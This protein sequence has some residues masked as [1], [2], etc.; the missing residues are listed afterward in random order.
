MVVATKNGAT[1]FMGKSHTCHPQEQEKN[2][3]G[4][5]KKILTGIWK[6]I[7]ETKKDLTK[8]GVDIVRS[9]TSKIGVGDKTLFWV[10]TWYGDKPL[11]EKFP[12]IYQLAKEKRAKVQ[13]NYTRPNG[14][15]LWDWAWH[16]TPSTVNERQQMEELLGMLNQVRL[17]ERSDYWIWNG[18]ENQDF[19]VKAVRSTL[20]RN[21]NLNETADDFFW[22]NWATQKCS[23]FVRRAIKGKIPTATKLRERGVPVLSGMCGVC[24]SEEETPDHVLV[25]CRVAENVWEQVSRWVKMDTASKPAT[26]AE[27]FS[28]LNDFNWPK[29]KKKAVHAIFLLTTWVIWKN[30]NEKIFRSRAGETYRMIEEIKEESYHWMKQRSKVHLESW[31]KW[32]YFSW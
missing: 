18:G 28:S 8:R 6:T 26:L 27:V 4:S 13:D 19:S 23:M 9:L 14:G 30:R 7:V 17:S 11:K 31:E 22:N 29:A 21:I 15:V 32:L 2:Y 3:Y 25:K 24:D 16:K 1:P 5:T 20:A 10:D 12:L